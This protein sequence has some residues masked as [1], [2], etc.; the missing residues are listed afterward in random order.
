M[1]AAGPKELDFICS[2]SR[3]QLAAAWPNLFFTFSEI[4]EGLG[5]MPTQP[6]QSL[7]MCTLSFLQQRIFSASYQSCE[8]QADMCTLKSCLT[9]MLYEKRLIIWR[10]RESGTV[11]AVFLEKLEEVVKWLR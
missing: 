8:E 3:K 5:F 11:V 6:Q 7:D 9:A 2:L 1:N 4:A 10:D